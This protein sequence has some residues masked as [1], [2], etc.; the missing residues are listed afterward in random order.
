MERV[1]EIRAALPGDIE[2]RLTERRGHATDIARSAVAGEVDAL[3][4][5]SGDGGFNEVLNGVDGTI[6]IGF[7]PGGNTSVLS[8]ARVAARSTARS[9][10]VGRRTRRISLGRVNGR[11]FGFSAGIGFDAELV[12]GVDALGRRSD[13]KRPGDLA[14]G[15]VTARTLGQAPRPLR[16]CARSRRSRPRSTRPRRELQPVH[17]SLGLGSEWLAASEMPRARA[18]LGSVGG[19]RPARLRRGGGRSAG[20]ARGAEC[21]FACRGWRAD[22]GTRGDRARV[23]GWCGQWR[24]PSRRREPRA[25]GGR[26]RRRRL[27]ASGVAARAGSPAGAPGQGRDRHPARIPGP[28]LRADRRRRALLRGPRADGRLVIGATVEERG[29]DTT[30]TAG[31]VHELLREAYR[32]LPDVAELELVETSAGLRP[33]SPGQRAADRRRRRRLCCW[34]PATSATACCSRR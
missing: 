2:V 11:R 3:Y 16:A 20:A 14:F 4:V 5:F 1:A 12:R 33:G 10:P 8:R 6:P 30:V 23:D 7:L 22:R 27:V 18:E 24:P 25:G 31:G 9:S 15:W 17:L 34:P 21:R 29:F 28:G 32:A 19:R 13:G 26:G